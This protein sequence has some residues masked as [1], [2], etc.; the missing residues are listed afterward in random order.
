MALIPRLQVVSICLGR[1]QQRSTQARSSKQSLKVRR[2]GS[3]VWSLCGWAGSCV[4]AECLV[5]LARLLFAVRMSIRLKQDNSAIYAALTSSNM[6][7]VPSSPNAPVRAFL[8]LS[9]RQRDGGRFLCSRVKRMSH[10]RRTPSCSLARPA[11]VPRARAAAEGVK[12]NSCY[13]VGQAWARN[14]P[15]GFVCFSDRLG[16]LFRVNGFRGGLWV[17]PNVFLA[18]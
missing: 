5:G 11:T 2:V 10:N 13:E 16:L 3:F 15:L 12:A 17:T 8:D 6:Q 9:A 18:G 7:L 14:F 1:L 4:G